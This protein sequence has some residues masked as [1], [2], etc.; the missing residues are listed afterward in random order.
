MAESG[1]G[2]LFEGQAELCSWLGRRLG[3]VGAV[4]IDDVSR[5]EGS[6]FSAETQMFTAH[7]SV[8][9]RPGGDASVSRRLV[10]RR[11]TPDPAVYPEQVPGLDV[12]IDIQYRVMSALT[13]HSAVPVAPLIGYE[14]DVSVLGSPFFVMGFVPG[15]V[16]IES[17]LYTTEGFFVDASPSQ[18]RT[19]I[20]N[21]LRALA[22][23]HAVDP[24]AAGLDWLTPPGVV[25]GTAQQLDLWEHYA[26]RELGDR[27]HEL[28]DEAIDWL[29][30]RVPESEQ[31]GLCRGDPRPGNIIWD[32]FDVA[33]VTDFEAAS[34]AEPEQDLGWWLMFDHWVHETYGI[35][36]LPGEPTREEQ[37]LMYCQHSGRDVGDM[38]FHEV[39]AATRYAAIV[40]RVMNRA[41]SRNLMPADHTVWRDN[42]ATVCLDLMLRDLR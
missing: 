32:D 11:E 12:E 27:T 21:G 35:E 5:P 18:R 42:P 16:P 13:D 4:V 10:F 24:S 19:M 39:F 17:P 23:V 3:A 34:I 9:D 29:R 38:T 2:A 33:C 30:P 15:L 8:E 7:Y 6:G 22:N 28:F 37:R 14:S 31:L 1:A 40:V 26:R 25:A 20:D 41:V 36:R